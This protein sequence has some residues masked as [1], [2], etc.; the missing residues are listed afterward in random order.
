MGFE[1]GQ[2]PFEDDKVIS[3]GDEVY[4]MCCST[5]DNFVSDISHLIPSGCGRHGSPCNS[6]SM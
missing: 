6:K 4:D 1:I 3:F 5:G 2:T